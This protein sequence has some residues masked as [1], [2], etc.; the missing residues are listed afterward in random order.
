MK[1]NAFFQLVHKEDGVYLKAYPAA[2]GGMPLQ[3]QDI[4]NYLDQKKY[5]EI[6][7]AEIREFAENPEKQEHELLRVASGKILPENEYAVITID[8]KGYMAKIRLYPPSSEGKRLSVEN[9]CDLLAQRG[10][11]HGIIKKNIELLW[12]ARLYC[13]DILVA[14]AT[15]PV[16][17]KNAVIT[18]HFDVDKTNKPM[19]AEDGT[20]DFHK[21]DMIER[22]QEGQKLATLEPA[23]PGTVGTDVLG[24]SIQPGKVNHLVLKH[25]K[26]IHLSEDKLEMYSE[27]S[28]NVTLV[29][30]TVFVS[31]VYEVPT[32]VGPSTGDIHYE[33]SVEIKGSVLSG[34]SVEAAGDITVNGAVEGAFLKAGGKI[35]LKRGIQGMGK[36][37]MEAE[38]DIISN[39]IESSIVKSGGKIITD[40]ILHSQAE[41]KEEIQ[42]QG[43][44]G[45][46]A[47]GNV[48][49]TLMIEARTAGSTMGTQ[50]ELE[51]GLDPSLMDR[52]HAIEKNME[53]LSEER[54]KLLQNLQILQKRL[55][56]TGKLEGEKMLML[57]LNTDRIKEIGEEMEKQTEEYESLDEQLEKSDGAGKIVIYDTAYP[58]VKLTISNVITYIHAETKHSAFVREGADIRVRGI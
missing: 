34:Y 3:T 16:Q 42:V 57:K 26:N 27:V 28:G 44:R 40:A 8:P 35:V 41:A 17:G 30:G 52:Y 1:R 9:I 24:R 14:K 6:N 55:K 56:M 49:S 19:M 15:M 21:L 33:G 4:L 47:G 46:I 58:G 36:G 38:G 48:R 37:T 23:V 25:G 5:L 43:K 20:V 7:A 11:Q 29:E 2:E 53:K 22:V 32:D 54:D 10:I 39:F 45:L 51:V 13:T 12:K 31:D 50:T 18:Y